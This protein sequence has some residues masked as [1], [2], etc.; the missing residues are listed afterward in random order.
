MKQTISRTNYMNDIALLANTPTQAKS[1]L[2]SL[3]QAAGD[4]G[5]YMNEHKTKKICFNKKWD[6][7]TLNGR[8]LTLVDKFTYLG[9][10]I[11]FTE[12][13]ISMQLAWTT[14]YRLSIIWKANLPDKIKRNFSKQQLCQF[15]YMDAPHGRWSSVERKS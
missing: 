9:S 12:N 8:S 5:C 11:L 13:V 3:K 14:V 7:S 10:S 1:L 15:Y 6:L 2:H 4:I